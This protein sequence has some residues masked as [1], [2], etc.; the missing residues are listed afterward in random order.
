MKKIYLYIIV[1]TIGIIFLPKSVFA[2]NENTNEGRSISMSTD[3]R[4]WFKEAGYGMMIHWLVFTS[5]R[6]VE[7]PEMWKLR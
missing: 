2:Y 7:R 1:I 6:R 3:T 5:G 4:K